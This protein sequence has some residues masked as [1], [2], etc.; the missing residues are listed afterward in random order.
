MPPSGSPHESLSSSDLCLVLIF[1][2][3]E[4]SL[5]QDTQLVPVC[6]VKWLPAWHRASGGSQNT[7][8]RTTHRPARLT[9]A[10]GSQS[11]LGLRAK[12]RMNKNATKWSQRSECHTPGTD[13]RGFLVGIKTSVEAGVH[14]RVKEH[15]C[16]PEKPTSQRK[17]ASWALCPG[18]LRTPSPCTRGPQKCLSS[19]H[20][21]PTQ[22][23][24]K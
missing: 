2:S 24:E 16:R 12:R 10:R 21:I 11:S 20:T 5:T 23:R 6:Q 17:A 18:P 9:A 14:S 4:S 13:R 15:T 3:R 7:G 1:V 19:F 22:V 8:D